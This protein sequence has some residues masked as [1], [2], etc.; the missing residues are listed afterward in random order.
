M[1]IKPITNAIVMLTST[2]NLACQYCFESHHVKHMS[3]ETAKATLDFL[4]RNCRGGQSAQFVFFG[5]EPLLRYDEVIVPIIEYS[6]T[7]GKPTKFSMT[8]NGTLL[9]PEKL[10]YLKA[11]G[12]RFMLSFDG[13]KTTQD[14]NRPMKCGESGFDKLMA[15]WPHIMARDSSTMVRGTVNRS[16]LPM[17]LENILFFESIGVKNLHMLPNV[18]DGWGEAERLM[19][20]E[21]LRNYEDYILG[22]YRAGRKP[23]LFFDYA[24]GFWRVVLSLGAKDRR[25]L[26]SSSPEARCGMGVRG[27]CSIDPDGNL[28]GCHHISPLTPESDWCIGNVQDGADEGKIR[29]LIAKYDQYA[30]GNERCATCPLDKICAGGCTST[31]EMVTG[32]PNCVPETFCV[33]RREITDSAYRVANILGDEKNQLFKTDFEWWCQNGRRSNQSV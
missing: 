2:C 18:W 26:Y 13:G 11:N 22:A 6:K 21:E 25:T 1:E 16:N 12:V 14:G 31:N 24:R 33:W 7:L 23:L 32:D 10:D 19:L 5:G 30:I 27:S 15:I 29:R 9:T 28:Y 8:T 3:Y 4:H 20:R 17:L